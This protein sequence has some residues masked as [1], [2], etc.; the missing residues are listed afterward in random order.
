MEHQLQYLL[1]TGLF[2]NNDA[3]QRVMHFTK[4]NKSVML[5]LRLLWR[6]EW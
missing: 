2:A 1:F 4:I 5:N 6:G 3:L